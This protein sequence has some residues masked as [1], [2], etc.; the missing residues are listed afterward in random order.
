MQITLHNF[1][2]RYHSFAENLYADNPEGTSI[3]LLTIFELWLACDRIAKATCAFMKDYD[4]DIPVDILSNLLLPFKLQMDRLHTVEGY[5][6]GR[7]QHSSISA[8]HLFDISS[9]RGFPARY[10]DSSSLH[11]SL[12]STISAQ[13]ERERNAR[14]W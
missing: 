6:R 10:F 5:L 4:P 3:M 12:I 1:I 2:V 8:A 7:K 13:A 14:K 11:Q 9:R